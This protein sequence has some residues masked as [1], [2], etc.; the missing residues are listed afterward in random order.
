MTSLAMVAGMVPLAVGHGTGAAQTAP[1]G[2]AVVGG[3]LAAT[4]ATLVLLPAVFALVMGGWR[5]RSAS[6]DPD[7]PVSLHFDAGGALAV[8]RNGTTNGSPESESA[9]RLGRP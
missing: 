2:R 7:D 6:L 9:V 5:G 1:L 8:G 3:L 4:G